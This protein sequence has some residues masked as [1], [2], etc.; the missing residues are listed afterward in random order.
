MKQSK[1]KELSSKGATVS[2]DNKNP[3]RRQ[4]IATAGKL[5]IQVNKGAERGKTTN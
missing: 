1:V 2:V 5:R 3:Q 4:V